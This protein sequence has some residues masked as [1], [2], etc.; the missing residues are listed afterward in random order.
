MSYTVANLTTDILQRVGRLENLAG[1]TLLGAANS[2]QSLIA[3]RLLDRRSDLLA[4]G[5]ISIPIPAMGYS[6]TLPD[7]FIAMAEKPKSQDIYTDWMMGVVASYNTLTGNLV[8]NVSES[9]GTDTLDDWSIATVPVPGGSSSNLGVSTTSLTVV[10][11]GGT[12]T[13]TATT[14]MTL[15]VG[16]SIYILPA[17][18]PLNLSPFPHAGKTTLQPTYLSDDEEHEDVS[19]WNWYGLYGWEWE[20]PS[21]R[22]H[23]YKI[24]G[25]TLYVRP[26]AILP[27]TVTG[28][29]FGLP[30]TLT[31]ASTIPWNGLFDELFRAGIIRIIQ[32][33]IEIPEVDADFMLFFA[34]EF[35]TVIN[36]RNHLL[37]KT[38]TSRSSFM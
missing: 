27:I 28:R 34:R 3:K 17:T 29:Y 8:V 22:P 5:D 14:G 15:S 23:H 37:P 31:D 38:R 7:G 13:L 35:D 4:T 12:A 6:G 16:D 2:I 21:K 24:I 33:G 26:Y 25:A 36:T 32:K 9:D 20:P 10:A 19:W 30:T 18:M 1:I 11:P